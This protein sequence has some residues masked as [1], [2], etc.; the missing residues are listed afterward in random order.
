MVCLP[1]HWT[2]EE[3]PATRGYQ[4]SSSTTQQRQ[5]TGSQPRAYSVTPSFMAGHHVAG[6]AAGLT[7]KPWTTRE[8]GQQEKTLDRG[9]FNKGPPWKSETVP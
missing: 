8:E 1:H 6:S 7:S 5:H 4:P 3:F 9:P 2:G